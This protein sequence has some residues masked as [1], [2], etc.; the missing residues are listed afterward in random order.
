MLMYQI[1]TPSNVNSDPYS[2]EMFAARAVANYFHNDVTLIK[3]NNLRTADDQSPNV[4]INLV[5][6]KMRPD[7]AINRIRYELGKANKIKQLLVVH[8][9]GKVIR[10]K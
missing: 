7:S 3:Q 1:H 4:I 2:H 6:C 5:R 9:N 10:L 8:K